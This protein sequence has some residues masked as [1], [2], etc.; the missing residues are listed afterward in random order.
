MASSEMP[1]FARHSI[2]S[3]RHFFNPFAINERITVLNLQLDTICRGPTSE[4][5]IFSHQNYFRSYGRASIKTKFGA[6]PLG[7][8]RE[9]R[10]TYYLNASHIS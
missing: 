7:G 8:V 9:K 10:Q 1:V 3:M 5:I 2:Q 6:C 4:E